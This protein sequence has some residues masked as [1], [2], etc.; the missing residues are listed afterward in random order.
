MRYFLELQYM[1][2]NYCGWQRQTN[3]PSV[4]QRLEQTLSTYFRTPI[5]VVGAGRTDTGVHASYYVAHFDLAEEVIDPSQAIYKLN[6]MLP[7]DV[8][9]RS[10]TAVPA[11]AH[12]RFDALER[13]YRYYI[14]PQKNPFT[15]SLAWHYAVDL[16]LDAMNRAAAVLLEECDFTSFAKLNSNNKTNLCCVVKAEWEV[17]G[18]G[19]LCFTIRANRFLR[20]MVRA[21]VGTLIDVGRGRYTVDQFVE[22]VRSRDLSRSSGGAPA[23][24]LYLTDVR[25]PQEI[26]ERKTF[27]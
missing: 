4:Q 21:I 11:T 17:L 20:N 6:R 22:I 23:E 27:Y 3:Q 1:G 16:D 8:A 26:F 19:K 2:S 9:I 13:E 10:M 18:D 14:E 15:R 12:A 24:G 5:E 7:D 25:Y